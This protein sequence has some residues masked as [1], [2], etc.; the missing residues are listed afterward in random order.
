LFLIFDFERYTHA[1]KVW[2]FLRYDRSNKVV[3]ENDNAANKSEPPASPTPT[4][5][6]VPL[7]KWPENK[8]ESSDESTVHNV[9]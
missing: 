5:G 6:P 8:A 7:F 4:F 9:N 2:E 1:K 3:S